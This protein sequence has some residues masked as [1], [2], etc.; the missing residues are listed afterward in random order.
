MEVNKSTQ[1]IRAMGGQNVQKHWSCGGVLG[2][3]RGLLDDLDDGFHGQQ[4]P[5][6]WRSRGA[7]G[8]GF[9]EPCGLLTLSLL[10]GGQRLLSRK[11]ASPGLET[12]ISLQAKAA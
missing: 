6:F 9:L 10:L 2:S 11:K 3:E 1:N 12:M 5:G 8:V 7:A 4:R